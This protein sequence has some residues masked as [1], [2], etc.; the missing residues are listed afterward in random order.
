M[1]DERDDSGDKQSVKVR[2]KKLSL[3]IGAMI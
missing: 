1:K 3:D 2:L